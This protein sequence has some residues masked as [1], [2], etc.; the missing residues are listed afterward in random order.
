MDPNVNPPNPANV[1]ANVAPHQ[2]PRLPVPVNLA[3]D[4]NASAIISSVSG[5]IRDADRL[6]A[7]GSN[8]GVWEEFLEERL[9][10]AINDPDYLAYESTSAHHERIARS[11]LLSSVDRSLRRDLQRLPFASSMLHEIRA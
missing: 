6:L 2:Q 8:L 4:R 11:I 3:D 9:R 7:D 5:Q 1:Q 10:D